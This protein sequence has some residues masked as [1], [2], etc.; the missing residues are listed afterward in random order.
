VLTQGNDPE[1]YAEGILKVCRAYLQSPLVCVAGISGGSLKRRIETIMENKL[2]L[3]LSAAHK[4]VLSAS[5]AAA[6]ALPLALGLMAVPVA[7]TQ[8]KAAPLPDLHSSLPLASQPR[9]NTAATNSVEG[10]QNAAVAED[11]TPPVRRS[12]RLLASANLIMPSPDV[13]RLLPQTQTLVALND[14]PAAP[15]TTQENAMLK[16]T[17]VAFTALLGL[18]QAATA[19]TCTLPSLVDTAKLEQV[20]GTNL[21]TVPVAINGTP[22]QFL[23]DIG[24]G[25]TQI[26]QTAVTQLGLPQSAKLTENIGAGRSS[27]MTPHGGDLGA[28]TNGGLGAVSVYDVRDKTGAAG[29]QTH[30]RVPSFTIGGATAQHLTFLL[31]N[32]ALMGTASE[33]YDGL[34][35]GDFF[36]QYDVE[37][38]F[39]GKQVNW[40]TPTKC[41][42]PNQVVFWSHSEVAVIPLTIEDGKITIPVSVQGHQI[43]AVI[44]TSSSRTVMRRDIAELIMGL[45]PDADM[46]PIA[47][48]MDGKGQPVYGH[49]FSQ[50]SFAGGG[51]TANN[52]PA[53][54]LTNSMTH[55]IN[56]GPVLGS[57][58]RSADARIPDLTLGM[59]VLK[60]LH[61]YIV[62]GQGKVYA[63]SAGVSG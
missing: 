35:T 60:Q 38:D 30:I 3:R 36:K 8:A 1:I 57:W 20:P 16:Q 29:A 12:H 37:L 13:S 42:D 62:P 63:T 49:T 34:L 39:A 31:A 40:L 52:V 14:P 47:G 59:D 56:S 58:A 10:V 48:L 15:S 43:N 41:T 55:P 7:P 5:A 24:T 44:D 46:A 26:G 6:L 22:K 51:V 19:Q 21:M 18:N 61:L 45:K 9:S 53:L 28:L 33:P 17:L 25:P 4:L 50:I 23:L 2:I 11:A 27:D 54:I 32:D